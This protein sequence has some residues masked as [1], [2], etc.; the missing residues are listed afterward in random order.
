M[1]L[2]ASR[3]AWRANLLHH[4]PAGN[5]PRFCSCV[6]VCLVEDA[7]VSSDSLLAVKVNFKVWRIKI[8]QSNQVDG[9]RWWLCTSL[10]QCQARSRYPNDVAVCTIA[11]SQ[12][13]SHLPNPSRCAPHQH[14]TQ[15]VSIWIFNLLTDQSIARLDSTPLDCRHCPWSF[16][17]CLSVCLDVCLAMC[18]PCRIVQSAKPKSCLLAVAHQTIALLWLTWGKWES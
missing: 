14:C 11:R 1:R 7:K 4:L 8:A 3:L 13:T 16:C 15:F 9:L 10:G 18:S 6:C 2:H 17:C 5:L 12:V